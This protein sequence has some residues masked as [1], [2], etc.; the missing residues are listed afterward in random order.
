M[1]LGAFP[2]WIGIP[3]A[4]LIAALVALL[5]SIDGGS[6]RGE[7]AEEFRKATGREL[8]I[9]GG[10]DLSV[11]LSPAASEKAV[12][13]PERDAEDRLKDVRKGFRGIFGG[14]KS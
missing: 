13:K 11:S 10:I 14:G 2:K 3:V 7:L 8:R 4:V 6:Y 12:E 5:Y 9:D 1:R